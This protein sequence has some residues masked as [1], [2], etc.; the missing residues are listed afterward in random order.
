M[1]TGVCSC[2][3]RKGG[4]GATVSS[5]CRPGMQLNTLECTRKPSAAKNYLAP[6][7]SSAKVEKPMLENL[8]KYLINVYI[9]NNT[10]NA[11]RK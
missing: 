11:N 1:P 9:K 4:S 2:H 10:E 3:D 6:D 7:V 8:H 5:G